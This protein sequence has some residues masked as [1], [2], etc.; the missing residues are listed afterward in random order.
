MRSGAYLTRVPPPLRRAHAL[1]VSRAPVPDFNVC[2]KLPESSNIRKPFARK[3]KDA[4]GLVALTKC[5]QPVGCLVSGE[6][7]DE[8]VRVI[9]QASNRL[10]KFYKTFSFGNV[11]GHTKTWLAD[12]SRLKKTTARRRM[13]CAGVRRRAESRNL[14]GM[15]VDNNREVTKT[16]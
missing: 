4:P 12:L 11:L 16:H 8:N 15:G 13:P 3:G 9:D 14:C 10:K 6:R 7:E 5:E 1:R 2:D